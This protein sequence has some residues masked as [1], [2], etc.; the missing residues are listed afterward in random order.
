MLNEEIIDWFGLLIKQLEYYVDVNTGKEKIIYEFK[1][2]SIRNSLITISN[3]KF[4]IT[5]GSQLKGYPNIGKGTI[6]RIDEILNTGKLAEVNETDISGKHMA[7]VEDLIRV[8]GIGRIKAY[9]MYTR[10]GIRSIED[11]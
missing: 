8:F 3:V 6:R 5:S 1:L 4:Q 7:Y 11:L 9:K 10:Y 2:N